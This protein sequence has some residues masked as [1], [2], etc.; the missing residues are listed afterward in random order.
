ML[1]SCFRYWAKGDD[2]K[3]LPNVVEPPQGRREWV[4]DQLEKNQ[5]WIRQDPELAKGGTNPS[6][7]TSVSRA[8]KL[9]TFADSMNY[10]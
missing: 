3:F 6:I 9:N 5:E 7:K 4:K 1:T 8:T 10:G 2:G